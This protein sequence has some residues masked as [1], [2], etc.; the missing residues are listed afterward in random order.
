M[1][2]RLNSHVRR[3]SL[4]PTAGRNGGSLDCRRNGVMSLLSNDS[5]GCYYRKICALHLRVLVFSAVFI[6]HRDTI[7]FQ[8][9]GGKILPARVCVGPWPRSTLPTP[10][11]LFSLSP[12]PGNLWADPYTETKTGISQCVFVCVSSTPGCFSIDLFPGCSC[13]S[14]KTLLATFHGNQPSN[15]NK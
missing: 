14:N 1:S 11:C 6:S 9:A 15:K 12:E 7:R 10:P 4:Q 13:C 3:S 2:R 8:L 5:A